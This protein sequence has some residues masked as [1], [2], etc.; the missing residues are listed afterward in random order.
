MLYNI[1][2]G[3]KVSRALERIKVIRWFGI[4]LLKLLDRV[5]LSDR[6]NNNVI[7][8]AEL[9]TEYRTS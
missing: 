5:A 7:P 4:W 8:I 6:V 1:T 3:L 9:Q 2:F